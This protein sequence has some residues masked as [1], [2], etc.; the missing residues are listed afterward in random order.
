MFFFKMYM[1]IS[2]RCGPP[3]SVSFRR[4]SGGKLLVTVSWPE[5]DKNAIEFYSVRYKA[6]GSLQSDEVGFNKV[7][8]VQLI[9]LDTELL[10]TWTDYFW[11]CWGWLEAKKL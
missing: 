11:Y 8:S 4:Q 1:Y 2:V 7:F 5:E 10:N 3:Y 6:L 9:E